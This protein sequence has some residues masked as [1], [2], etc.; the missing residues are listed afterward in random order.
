MSLTLRSSLS[1]Y[2]SIVSATKANLCLLRA[3]L[4]FRHRASNTSAAGMLA[5]IHVSMLKIH[6]KLYVHG[7]FMCES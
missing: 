3:R 6:A 1:H 7:Q 5:S 2:S 4:I